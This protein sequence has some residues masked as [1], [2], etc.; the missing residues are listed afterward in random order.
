[1][2]INTFKHSALL[3]RVFLVYQI[4]TRPCLSGESATWLLGCHLKAASR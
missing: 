3:L 4:T 1:M 2:H